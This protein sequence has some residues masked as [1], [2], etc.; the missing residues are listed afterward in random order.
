MAS[1]TNHLDWNTSAEAAQGERPNSARVKPSSR[2]QR[3]REIEKSDRQLPIGSPPK[4]DLGQIER[5]GCSTQLAKLRAAR[6]N[7]EYHAWVCQH[8]IQWRSSISGWVVPETSCQHDS[9]QAEH[10]TPI[11]DTA[12]NVVA[13]TCITTYSAELIIAAESLYSRR[14]YNGRQPAH[15]DVP[16]PW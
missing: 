9:K 7:E 14:D 12:H 13:I 10:T 4:V 16:D 1:G 8:A 15:P 11:V 2:Q 5:S 6:P 3:G